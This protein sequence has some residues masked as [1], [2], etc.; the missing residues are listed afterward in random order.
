MQLSLSLPPSKVKYGRPSPDDPLELGL[1][2]GADEALELGLLDGADEALELGATD[3]DDFGEAT[4]CGVFDV[5]PPLLQLATS[6]ATIA[7]ATAPP[8]RAKR[9]RIMDHLLI[10]YLSLQNK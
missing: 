4:P 10:C 8:D 5:D 6:T 3:G 1:A 9:E 2:E 7:I